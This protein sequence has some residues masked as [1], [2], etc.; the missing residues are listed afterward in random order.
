MTAKQ[1]TKEIAVRFATAAHKAFK[2]DM[3]DGEP[4]WEDEVFEALYN[5]WYSVSGKFYE[6]TLKQ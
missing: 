4:P 5:E 6:K 3:D 1:I 2:E